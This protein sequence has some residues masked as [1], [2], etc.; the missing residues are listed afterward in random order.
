MHIEELMQLIIVRPSKVSRGVHNFCEALT[1]DLLRN[2]LSSHFTISRITADFFPSRKLIQDDSLYIFVAPFPS[3]C[4]PDNSLVIVHDWIPLYSFSLAERIRYVPSIIRCLII[5]F[6]WSVTSKRYRLLCISKHVMYET[7]R[8]L[9]HARRSHIIDYA[10]QQTNT[11]LV[12]ESL[13]NPTISGQLRHQLQLLLLIDNQPHKNP[14]LSFS[15]LDFVRDL[16]GHV[17]GVAA[18]IKEEKESRR[19]SKMY[20][21]LCT[22]VSPTNGHLSKLML[23]SRFILYP[24]ITEGFGLPI[25]EAFLLDAIP[26]AYPSD[27]NLEI[28]GPDYPYYASDA[29]TVHSLM[30]APPLTFDEFAALRAACFARITQPLIKDSVQEW[31]LS[32]HHEQR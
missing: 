31:L 3:W 14:G 7:R 27:I 15:F 11:P 26:I 9:P 23:E 21:G 29:P 24:S 20:P 2:S 10:Y 25:Y 13:S 32:N 16:R 6:S 4:L 30:S 19:L 5:L 28:L 17:S 12:R 8:I 22:Y 18:I 1:S